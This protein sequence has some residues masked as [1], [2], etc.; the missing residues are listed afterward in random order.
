[1]P[2]RKSSSASYASTT[3][4][5]ESHAR[6]QYKQLARQYAHQ[7]SESSGGTAMH[8]EL[9]AERKMS[10]ITQTLIN[11]LGV[12]K[13]P[14]GSPTLSNVDGANEVFETLSLLSFKLHEISNH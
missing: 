1:M 13:A 9:C 8:N 4:E 10:R 14:A 2:D 5:L 11:T 7:H 12:Q 3:P 6:E